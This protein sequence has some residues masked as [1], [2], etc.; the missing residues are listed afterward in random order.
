LLLAFA[1]IGA[2]LVVLAAVVLT[3]PASPNRRAGRAIGAATGSEGGARLADDDAD[4]IAEAMSR[5]RVAIPDTPATQLAQHAA[6]VAA[7]QAAKATR[8]RF[9]E[10]TMSGVQG[11]GF[12]Q[13]LRVDP[14][15]GG[16]IYTSVPGSL[17][18]G[19]SWIWRSLDGGKTFKW[20]PAAAP[21]T[22][23]LPTCAGGGDTELAVD[24]KGHLYFNDL[25]LANFST[26]RSDDRG[27]T[28]TPPNCQSV[29]TGPDDRQWYATSGDPT[30]GGDV[31]LSY[32]VVGAANPICPG[33]LGNN[34]MV[35]ARSP[36]AGAGPDAGVHFAPSEPVTAPASCD[37]A[38][39]GNNEV[40]PTTHDIFVVH[41][42]SEFSEIRMGKCKNVDFTSN[43]S[44]LSCSDSLVAKLGKNRT[45]QN[46]PTLAIDSS[47]N[48]Y[49]VWPQI[50]VDSN[51]NVVGDTTLWFSSSTDDGA[52]WTKPVQVP[53][54]RLHNN[55]YPWIVAG[56]PGRLDIAWFGTAAT[57]SKNPNDPCYQ[58]GADATHGSWYLYFSRTKSATSGTP[59]FSRPI[60]AQRW[61]VYRGSMATIYSG[62]CGE[63]S[64]ADF[65]QVRL[66]HAGEAM[67]SYE[68]GIHADQ[69]SPH[70]MFIR[71]VRGP[72]ALAGK[73]VGGPLPPRQR[74]SDPAGDARYEQTGDVSA[75]IPNLDILGSRVT[76]TD[77][78][79]YMVKM[80]VASLK[81]LDPPS[82]TN[83]PDSVL[84]WQTQ[85][86]LTSTKSPV[87]GRN[88]FAYMVSEGGGKPAFYYGWNATE[89]VGGGVALTYPGVRQV[90]GTYTPGTA[91]KPGVIKIRVPVRH[92]TPVHDVGYRLLSATATTLTYKQRPESCP[93]ERARDRTFSL[94][95][96][97]FNLIDI[98]K[99]YDYVRR[100]VAI[101]H[102]H[103]DVSG[104]KKVGKGDVHI[105]LNITKLRARRARANGTVYF[106]DMR[107]DP[108]GPAKSAFTCYGGTTRVGRI[109]AHAIGARGRVHCVGLADARRFRLVVRDRGFN[110]MHTDRYSIRI[111]TKDG[112]RIYAFGSATTVGLGDLLVR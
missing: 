107:A 96:C 43:P 47:G 90:K 81:T 108:P 37:E 74:V 55:V 76:K 19:T 33:S 62:L 71:Q 20:I 12:E 78:L 86:M 14:R 6:D 77:S 41:D 10:P 63:R 73:T 58:S 99:A 34:Q 28:F 64:L 46:F 88:V 15:K 30:N 8:V 100:P 29:E 53:T 5:A 102:A 65:I 91:G 54:P 49:T 16:A 110:P 52:T 3:S 70:A 24:T 2:A 9:G 93:V 27:M 89:A 45:G 61:P 51:G 106:G 4:R 39:M 97:Y 75:N 95:G 40:S 111:F 44:G 35:M 57:Q 84:V 69:F 60:R 87:G 94:G 11:N 50:P 25:T 42:N 36:V 79:H 18:S 56:T 26:A 103:T 98:A 32:N 92:F 105:V 48:L 109:A 72:G 59:Q 104:D 80:R 1:S 21:D 22:G 85:F 66:G 101:G 38:I 68:Q 31:Y 13:D 67:I 7:A 112:K 83:D 17:S 23:K 82:N